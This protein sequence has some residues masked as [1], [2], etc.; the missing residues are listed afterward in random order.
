M[1]FNYRIQNTINRRLQTT[2]STSGVAVTAVLASCYANCVE[3]SHPSNGGPIYRT[4]WMAVASPH[5]GGSCRDK[6]TLQQ[7]YS[8]DITTV[9]NTLYTGHREQPN[10]YPSSLQSAYDMTIDYKKADWTQFTEHTE[11]TF[12]QTTIPT[13]IHTANRI[14]INIITKG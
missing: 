8:P 11:S 2:Q 12:S 14:F 9:F 1:T 3:T 4:R 10:T 5:E 6:Y 13:N 7:T